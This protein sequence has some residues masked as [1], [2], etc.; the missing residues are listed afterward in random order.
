MQVE[1]EFNIIIF[2]I[3]STIECDRIASFYEI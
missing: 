3:F 2:V 1:M